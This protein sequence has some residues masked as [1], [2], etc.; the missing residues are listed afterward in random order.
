VV[1]VRPNL[2]NNSFASAVRSR[3]SSEG[4]GLAEEGM[5]KPC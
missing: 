1:A 2:I 5:V 4:S 3:L